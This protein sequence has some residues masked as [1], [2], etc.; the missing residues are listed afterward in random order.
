MGHIREEEKKGD[1]AF[2]LTVE[3]HYDGGRETRSTPYTERGRS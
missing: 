1:E 3:W 2:D